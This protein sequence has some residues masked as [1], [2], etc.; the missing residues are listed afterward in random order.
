MTAITL[1]G[2]GSPLSILELKDVDMPVI[3]LAEVLV[4]VHA[5]RRSRPRATPQ[6]S[7]AGPLVG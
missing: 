4:L 7:V 1:S 3:K 2:C 5:G 6:C